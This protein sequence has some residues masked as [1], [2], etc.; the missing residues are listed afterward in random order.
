MVTLGFNFNCLIARVEETYLGPGRALRIWWR[1]GLRAD[2]QQM[3]VSPVMAAAYALEL[4]RATLRT[5]I[6][7]M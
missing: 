6:I 5:M 7:L 2:T 1:V 3:G 4:F